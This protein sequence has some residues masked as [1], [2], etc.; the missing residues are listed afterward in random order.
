MRW[1]AAGGGPVRFSVAGSNVLA[2]QLVNGAQ[3]K[4]VEIVVEE[5][6]GARDPED[7]DGNLPDLEDPAGAD[8]DREKMHFSSLGCAN[9]RDTTP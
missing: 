4:A 8:R 5:R 6:V 1:R 3:R 9:L 7:R 2:R